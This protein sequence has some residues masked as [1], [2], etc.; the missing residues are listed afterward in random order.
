[1]AEKLLIWLTKKG[2]INTLKILSNHLTK[3]NEATLEFKKLLENI[4]EDKEKELIEN[5]GKIF[6]IEEGADHL[7]RN[8]ARELQKGK[9]PPIDREDALHLL[10][11]HE[12]IIDLTKEA[13]LILKIIELDA[14]GKTPKE[15][16][17]NYINLVEN[18]INELNTY[19][20]CLN[21]IATNTNEAYK[22]KIK[23]EEIEHLIDEEYFK[24][25][26]ELHFK[27]GNQ[28]ETPLLILL[29]DILNIIE[30]I[31]DTIEDSSDLIQVIIARVS[32]MLFGS[33]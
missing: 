33:E 21:K 7:A 20:L 3:V 2:G 24:I 19:N 32:A 1:M 12:K 28:I 11:K 18:V 23:V 22:L 13:T 4:I 10:W 29:K 26:R 17:K 15:L 27:Y 16:L 31:S 8:I 5:M 6:L 30:R 25:R 9:L 14:K